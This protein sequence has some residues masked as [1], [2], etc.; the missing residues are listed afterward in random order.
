MIK[1]KQYL[2]KHDFEYLARH[3]HVSENLWKCKKCGVFYIQHWGLGIGFKSKNYTDRHWVYE[4]NL[5]L[6]NR[7]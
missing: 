5:S 2:C 1:L 7:H 6:S 3:K 4:K